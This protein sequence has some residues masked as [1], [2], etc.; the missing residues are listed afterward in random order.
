MK[1][2][3]IKLGSYDTAEHGWTLNTLKLSDP[4]QKVNYADKPGGDGAW[5]LSTAHTDGIPRY[6]NRTLLVILECSQGDRDHREQLIND[7]VNALDGLEWHIVLPD[8]PEHYLVARLH[9]VVDYSDLAHAQ[10]TINGTCEP[11]LYYSRENVT[12][13]PATDQ[14]TTIYLRNDG[15]RAVVPRLTVAGSA[16]LTYNG[17]SVDLNAGTYEWPTLLLTTGLHELLYS[18]TGML[19]ITYREAVLR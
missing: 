7:M 16:R 5:D 8:R 19:T 1:K 11:W 15:R 17:S 12:E 10:V 2:R 3:T 18:S 9:L 4:D 14:T 6:N 13:L